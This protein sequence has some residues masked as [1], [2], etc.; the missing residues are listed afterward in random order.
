[1]GGKRVSEQTLIR[2]AKA[3]RHAGY[4]TL[5]GQV[6][7]IA[8]DRP[9]TPQ[10]LTKRLREVMNFIEAH[11]EDHGY[12]PSFQ[13]IA[14]HFGYRSLATV[15]EHLQHLEERGH[16]RRSFNLARSI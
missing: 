9:T 8:N 3:L 12:A 15:H 11:I 13:E 1:M 2:A 7:R 16:I 10:P 4:L 14:D 5:A 6:E